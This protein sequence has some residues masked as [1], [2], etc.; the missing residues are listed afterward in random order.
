[1]FNFFTIIIN[2]LQDCAVSK[3]VTAELR[4]KEHPPVFQAHYQSLNILGLTS[5][6]SQRSNITI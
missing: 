5:Q 4:E 2:R 3:Q 1:M 6:C